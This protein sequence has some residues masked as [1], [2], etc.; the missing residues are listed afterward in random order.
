MYG[1]YVY[2][3]I[4][5]ILKLCDRHCAPRFWKLFKR[6]S[7]QPDQGQQRVAAKLEMPHFPKGSK[8]R[9]SRYIVCRGFSILKPKPSAVEALSVEIAQEVRASEIALF[10]KDLAPLQSSTIPS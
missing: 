7:I 8:Y 4:Y 10:E 9:Y 3:I 5:Y 1:I 2:N 6:H